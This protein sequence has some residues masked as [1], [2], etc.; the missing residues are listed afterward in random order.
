MFADKL[1][2][3][4]DAIRKMM[5]LEMAVCSHM[6]LKLDA[7]PKISLVLHLQVDTNIERWVPELGQIYLDT[8]V[9]MVF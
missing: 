4:R 7:S 6:S 5:Q 2:E 8:Q 3:F 9:S 1:Q